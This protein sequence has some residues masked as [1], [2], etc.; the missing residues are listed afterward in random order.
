MLRL[1]EVAELDEVVEGVGMT[2][3]WQV[4]KFNKWGVLATE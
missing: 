1:R 3:E 4:F 2:Q